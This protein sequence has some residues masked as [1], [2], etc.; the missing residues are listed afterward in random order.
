MLDDAGRRVGTVWSAVCADTDPYRAQWAL[1]A[2]G[3]WRS[4]RRLV[5]VW[6]A[7]MV[8]DGLR[9]PYPRTLIATTPAVHRDDLYDAPLLDRLAAIYGS[10]NPVWAA[11]RKGHQQ[12]AALSRQPR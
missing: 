9:V 8:P 7:S 6:G 4:R 12:H 10:P 11:P 1:V 3:A 2:L 5:Q